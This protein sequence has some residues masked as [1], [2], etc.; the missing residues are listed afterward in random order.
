MNSPTLR[1][2]SVLKRRTE[3]S[4]M[5]IMILERLTLEF[6]WHVIFF[7]VWWYSL[8]ARQVGRGCWHLLQAGNTRL[9]PGLWLRHLFVPMYGQT[10]WQGRLMSVFMRII[11]VVIRA[12][13]LLLWLFMVT[14]LFFL[15]IIFPVFLLLMLIRA[16]T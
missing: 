7:P 16:I 2:E 13:A 1:S 4:F 11:N 5:W 10:D 6:I 12:V 15:W 9:A 8:G 3:L 14:A